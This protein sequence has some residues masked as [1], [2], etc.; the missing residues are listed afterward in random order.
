MLHSNWEQFSFQP[1]LPG[2]C[3]TQSHSFHPLT[4]HSS[5]RLQ[6]HSHSTD[7]S[8]I[9]QAHAIIPLHINKEP[10]STWLVRHWGHL[11]KGKNVQ[12]ELKL[13]V[14]YCVYSW[15]SWDKYSVCLAWL[16]SRVGLN[17]ARILLHVVSCLKYSSQ[18]MHLKWQWCRTSELKLAY[19]T[20]LNAAA[21]AELSIGPA[22]A[23]VKVAS[24]LI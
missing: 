9:P 1:V 6:T 15:P 12:A 19:I 10:D 21:W 20:A 2:A 23:V 24:V 4:I 14:G 3:A 8:L 18:M 5:I 22:Q 7:H 13:G 11:H 16:R 17:A